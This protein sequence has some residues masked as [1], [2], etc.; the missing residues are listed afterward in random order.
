MTSPGI[1][2]GKVAIVTGSARNIGRAIALALAAQGADI[3]V[4]AHTSRDDAERTAAELKALGVQAGLHFADIADPDQAAGLIEATVVRFG[5]LDILVNN[6]SFRS[7][8]MLADITPQEWRKALSATLD[9]TFFCTQA[10]AKPIA[11]AG[12]GS[13]VN[14]GGVASY[15]APAG[16]VHAVTAKA[17]IV[18]MTRALATEL[19]P[20]KITVNAVVPGVIDT[21]RGANAG[22]L[23]A[24]P[25]NL[26]GRP[27][28][29][30]EIADMVAYLCGPSARYIT[31][32][33]MHVNGG[34]YFG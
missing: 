21:I 5:R 6:V 20:S 24:M 1:L 14:L 28:R 23:P 17:G 32:Q 2:A 11:D 7:H 22:M 15:L 9:G 8:R 10:A 25:N 18:G 27:G 31:G 29:P 26:A 4:H 33:M 13:I 30:D 3:M 19:A 34:A 16:R 12:G